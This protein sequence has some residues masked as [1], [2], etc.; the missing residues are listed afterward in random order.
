MASF[1]LLLSGDPRDAS[2]GEL[3]RRTDRQAAW[4]A[5][6]RAAGVLADGGRIEGRSVRVRAPWGRPAV[7]DVPAD[8][9]GSVRSW[10]L[11]EAGDLAAAVALAESCP[12]AVFGDVRVLA[13]DG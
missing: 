5:G 3:G 1:V 8:V 2:A 12:E 13:V 9:I 7:I 11:V 10:L 6:L 4:V